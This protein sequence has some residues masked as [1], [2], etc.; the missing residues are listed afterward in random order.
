MLKLT[1]QRSFKMFYFEFSCI[2]S[3]FYFS[4]VGMKRK[5]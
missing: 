2:L 3:M 1:Y 5:M 4:R